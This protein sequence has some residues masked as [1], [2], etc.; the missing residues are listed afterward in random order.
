MRSLGLQAKAMAMTT[1]CFMPPENWWGY[2]LSLWRGIPTSSSISPAFSMASS[3]FSFSWIMM[4][5]A[6]CSPTVKTGFRAVIGSWKIIEISF[7]LTS[8]RLVM[9]MVLMSCPSISSLSH[10]TTP[11][12][13]GTR[14]SIAR[15]VVVFPAPVSPTR[16]NVFLYPSFRL[17]PLTAYTMPS[18]VSNL[19]LRFSIFRISF[20]SLMFLSFSS[21]FSS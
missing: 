17:I 11:G 15:A 1:L 13:S 3:F 9:D 10:S 2:S 6:I 18:S 12:G 7:P 21:I 16:P 19:T 20:S 5:S 4:D 14:R 8:S